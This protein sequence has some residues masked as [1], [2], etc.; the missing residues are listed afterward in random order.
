M[1]RQYLYLAI[2]TVCTDNMYIC[3]CF[4]SQVGDQ[5]SKISGA[6]ALRDHFYSSKAELETTLKQCEEQMQ[7]VDVLGVSVPT[8]LD[9][10][11]VQ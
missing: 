1:Y 10:Y 4:C 6:L 2:R 11:K 5:K 3:P 7:A 8:K 9:R